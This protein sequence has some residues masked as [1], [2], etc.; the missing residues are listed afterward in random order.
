MTFDIDIYNVHL[1]PIY[2]KLKFVRQR[3]RSKFKV[4]GVCRVLSAKV[5][6]ATL[7]EGFQL[8]LHEANIV[9]S[10]DIC[11]PA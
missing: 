4:A 7:S 2:V 11:C 10:F 9:A 8:F 6:I 5:V 3:D 1:D